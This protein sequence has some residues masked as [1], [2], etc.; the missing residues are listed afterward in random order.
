MQNNLSAT[1]SGSTPGVTV[2][3]NA[4]ANTKGVWTQLIASTNYDVF[5][6]T[7]CV[8]NVFT[9]AA[10][11]RMLADIGIG[12]NP[13]ETVIVPNIMVGANGNI[14]NGLPFFTLPMFIPKGTR[15]SGRCQDAVGGDTCSIVLFLHGGGQQPWH[16]F[17][18]GESIGTVSSGAS[19]GLAHTA[20]SS[21]AESTWTNIGSV[22]AHAL[23]A[24]IPMVQSDTVTALNAMIYHVEIGINSVT[25]CE[26]L[27]STTATE[28]VNMLAPPFLTI[29]IFRQG[30]S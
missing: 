11:I 3:S 22:T 14:N 15:I 16:T 18:R 26:Y 1:P 21:G 27:F 7:I 2:T 6:I 8:V 23:E 10:A 17:S 19:G 13:N 24:V 20:G 28:V 30:L 29:V 9:S 25:L 5:G 12:A 4:T